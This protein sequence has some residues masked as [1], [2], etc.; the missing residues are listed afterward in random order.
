MAGRCFSRLLLWSRA[1]EECHCH[2]IDPLSLDAVMGALQ[3]RGPGG[4]RKCSLL[5]ILH[6]LDLAGRN[7][8]GEANVLAPSKTAGRWLRKVQHPLQQQVSAGSPGIAE[9]KLG[10]P[11]RE[12]REP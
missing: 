5:P 9:G 8:K 10:E 1:Q 4:G 7:G 6:L 11:R 12:G 2:C 3:A